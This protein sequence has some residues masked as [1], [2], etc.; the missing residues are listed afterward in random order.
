MNQI[1]PL[2]LVASAWLS[3]GFALTAAEIFVDQ[4]A[5]SGGDGSAG[6]PYQT[7]GEALK[8]LPPEE[9]ATVTIK[10]GLYRETLTLNQG[11]TTESPLIIR[12]SPGETVQITGFQPL[13]GWKDEGGGLYSVETPDR[14]NAL[15]VDARRQPLSRFPKSAQPWIRVTADRP[16]S[17]ELD[18]ESA[19]ALSEAALAESYALI[20]CSAINGEVTFPVTR[21]DAAARTLTVQSAGPRFLPKTDDAV[22]FL[23]SAEWVTEPGEWSCQPAGDRWKVTFRPASPDDLARTQIRNQPHVVRI[24]G[25]NTVLDGVEITGGQTYGIYA[26]G[27]T[28]VKITR[29]VIYAN[30]AAGKNGVNGLGLRI[31]NCSNFTLD[32]SIIFANY[33]HGLGITQ[34]E[35]VV[36]SGCEITAN[37][38]DGLNFSGRINQPDAPLRHVL[39]KN[40]YIHRHF[41]LGHPDNTQMFGNVRDVTY[42]NNVLFLAG[43]NA[44]IQECEGMAFRNNLFFGALARHVILGHNSSNQAEFTNNTFAFANYGAIGTAGEGVKIY[45]NIFYQNVLSYESE[46]AVGDRN[47]FWPRTDNAPVLIRTKPAWR[48]YPNPADFT[49]EYGFETESKMENPDFANVPAYQA[50]TRSTFFAGAKDTVYLETADLGQFAPGDWIEINGD[51]VARRVETVG[52]DSLTFTP[53]LPTLP[54]RNA[55]V[56]K[57]TQN[58][59]L[60]ISVASP[61]AGGSGQPG[62]NL[63]LAAYQRGE[64]DGSGKRSIPALSPAAQAAMPSPDRFVYPFAIP[65]R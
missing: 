21:L 4:K 27:A 6:A 2:I 24:N 32:S 14:V 48:G 5:A 45:D 39:L 35:N 9:G 52:A 3:G 53:A 38:G 47:L 10:G 1:T 49:S 18:L 33:L 56:W 19:P 34:G 31:D 55:F 60:K 62:A 23:N 26:A 11:G 17:A 30:G 54:F 46:S 61:K 37:D 65:A 12:A 25:G 50:I 15:F 22:I 64:L 16:D 58:S 51:G 13:T 42:E 28:N 36:V 20:Y 43:Q 29:C 59:N 40:C 7:I 63:D 57:W 41:Y 44:M 8:S